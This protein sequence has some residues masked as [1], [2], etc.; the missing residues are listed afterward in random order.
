M[1]DEKPNQAA[2]NFSIPADSDLVYFFKNGSASRGFGF[3]RISVSEERRP[4]IQVDV[5]ISY[6]DADAL[7]TTKIC[8]VEESIGE[9]GVGIVF[10]TS[11]LTR[12]T[13]AE[14]VR[15]DFDVILPAPLDESESELFIKRLKT[16]FTVVHHRL[17]DFLKKVKFGSVSLQTS[18]MPISISGLSADD[19]EVRSQDSLFVGIIHATKSVDLRTSNSPISIDV[20]ITN[21][22]TQH[23]G[24]V[25]LK[26][27]NSPIDASLRLFSEN[28]KVG[29]AFLVDAR[30]ENA[31]I[32]LYNY[33]LPNR[34]SLVMKARTSRAPVTILAPPE[35]EGSFQ[36]TSEL[37]PSFVE[38]R[39][40]EDPEARGRRRSVKVTSNLGPDA[41]AVEGKVW[42][43]EK[44]G[45]LSE[46][47]L[48]ST[49]V[50]ETTVNPI[51]FKLYHVEG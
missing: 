40:V 29:G 10:P 7:N 25:I 1:N 47:Q 20:S 38:P 6:R 27:S 42:W 3:I 24:E 19:V 5:T 34:S 46:P 35:F 14:Q 11:D 15:F 39:H 51:F 22:D 17:D 31:H 32:G 8:L 21:N 50:V 23:P 28:S 2:V 4:D 37:S 16:N 41:F 44:H 49:I 9:T 48:N 26:T 43:N 12:E 36:F 33:A 13:E 18:F 30:T 45:E